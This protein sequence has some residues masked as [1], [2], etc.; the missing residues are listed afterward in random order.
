[1][2]TQRNHHITRSGDARRSCLSA[3][4]VRPLVALS[5]MLSIV[6]LCSAFAATGP[7][8]LLRASVARRVGH[9][10][11]ASRNRACTHA[12]RIGIAPRGVARRVA[13]HV[14]APVGNR[15]VHD[16]P[17]QLGGG[18]P[19]A[20]IAEVGLQRLGQ[21]GGQCKEAVNIWV[22]IASNGAQHLGGDYLANY[23][24]EGGNEVSRDQAVEGD[25]IQLNGPNGNY[26]YEGMHT[27][28]V[29]SH[30]PGSEVFKV[31]DSNS[32]LNEVV[33]EH[34]W[35][36][37]AAAARY[38][39]SVHI[40][41]M[42]SASSPESSPPDAPPSG[43]LQGSSPTLQ[44][45]SGSVVQAAGPTAGSGGGT[46]PAQ[47]SGP[48]FTVMNTSTPPPDGVWFRNS[49]HTADTSR[50]TG[51]GVYM[52]ER[53]ELH[54]YAFGDEVGPYADRLWYY[55][56]NVSRPTNDGQPNVGF[57][58]AHYINDG[59]VANELDAGVPAC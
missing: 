27:A 52:N 57:L 6:M 36:P 13:R 40:W 54:C 4:R 29:V 2:P 16:A 39:L 59:K 8:E 26:Y 46:P 42:G 48:V 10:A 44:G 22:A 14:C 35:N 19:N 23:R 56:T 9:S 51:L 38:A 24:Y 7:A 45:G 32:E 58:D 28:V 43:P 55:T 34:N 49:P 37:Y 5:C 15:A 31:V 17:P 33:R 12:K 3:S 30:T 1:M 25:V 21:K 20:R 18:Y 41:R 53:V 47:S 11:N 50:V